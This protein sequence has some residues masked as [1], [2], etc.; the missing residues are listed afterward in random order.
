[1]NKTPSETKKKQPR[2]VHIDVYCTASEASESSDAEEDPSE[3]SRKTVYESKDVRVVHTREEERLPQA[4]CRQ[5]R[6]TLSEASTSHSCIGGLES[7]DTN[8]SSLYP[9]QHSSFASGLSLPMSLQTEDSSM[10]SS[11]TSS[12]AIFSEDLI[13]SW[14]D[15]S[16]VD[17]MRRTDLSLAHSESFEY[18]DNKDRWRIMQK[19][20]AWGGCEKIWKSPDKEYRHHLQQKRHQQYM[21][22]KGSPF[23]HWK[24]NDEDN[25]EDS[26]SASSDTSSEM[27]WSFGNV[28]DKMKLIK[29]EDTVRRASRDAIFPKTESELQKRANKILESGSLSDSA[30][31]SPVHHK[32]RHS[33]GPFGLKESSPPKAKLESTITTPFSAVPGRKTDQLSKAEK[34]GTIIG[35]FRKPG[36][37]VGPSKNPDCSCYNCRQF[38]EEMGYR[39]RTRSLG[40]TPTRERDKWR[41]TLGTLIQNRHNEDSGSAEWDMGTAV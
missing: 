17:S 12:C 18:E 2:T 38:Y 13:T 22:R 39:N 30:A 27:A 3:S 15:T 23:P 37:H 41:A 26:S 7:C 32:F 19:E 5:K 4:L 36:H 31:P 28:S 1:M 10:V 8:V 11:V 35:T 34:F 24:P 9:S 16:D 6:R 20:K 25:D 33:I 21:E 40:D 29:R 14:K